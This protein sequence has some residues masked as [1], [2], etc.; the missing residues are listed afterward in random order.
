MLF[1]LFFYFVMQAEVN[2][3]ERKR[4]ERNWKLLSNKIKFANFTQC[5]LVLLLLFFVFFCFF[6]RKGNFK[7]KL[8]SCLYFSF[9][10]FYLIIFFEI[11]NRKTHIKFDFHSIRIFYLINNIIFGFCCCCL[12]FKSINDMILFIFCFTR[13]TGKK[14]LQLKLNCETK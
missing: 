11:Q 6:Y 13:S 1:S 7:R 4:S 5:S 9:T 14:V 3:N 12:S 8:T 2:K 10:F